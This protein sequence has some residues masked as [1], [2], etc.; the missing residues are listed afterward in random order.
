MRDNGRPLVRL[1]RS[2]FFRDIFISYAYASIVRYAR[3]AFGDNAFGETE[4]E[5]LFLLSR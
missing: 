5:R 4:N 3:D 2:R 1:A